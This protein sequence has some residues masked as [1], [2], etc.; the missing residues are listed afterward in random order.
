MEAPDG[1]VFTYHSHPDLPAP[2]PQETGERDQP[3]VHRTPLDFLDEAEEPAE[4]PRNIP[5]SESSDTIWNAMIL[6]LNRRFQMMI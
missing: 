1:W 6:Y 4:E 2:T 3:P 5:A